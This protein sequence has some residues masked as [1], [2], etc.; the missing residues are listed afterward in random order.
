LC[1]FKDPQILKK[2]G[3][4]FASIKPTV[5]GLG[6]PRFEHLSAAA[7]QKGSA[8]DLDDAISVGQEER[9]ALARA[10]VMKSSIY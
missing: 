5:K 9:L 3:K 10:T 4:L 7:F 8:P 1:L 6:H 2:D